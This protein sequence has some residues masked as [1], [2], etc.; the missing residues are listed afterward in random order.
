MGRIHMNAEQGISNS[1]VSSI[2]SGEK[3]LDKVIEKS[4]LVVDVTT[5]LHVPRI[6]SL[7][8]SFPRTVSAFITPSGKASVMLL[9]DENRAIRCSSLEAQ[10]Y[11]AILEEEWGEVHLSGHVGRQW[12][13]AGCREV[14]L[15]MSNEL[16]NLHAAILSRQIRVLSSHCDAK[17][18]IWEYQENSGGVVPHDIQVFPYHATTLNDWG[19]AWDDGFL[20]EVT[21]YRQGSLPN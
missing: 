1:F 2:V 12:V 13:G 5:T 10:Y 19:I 7:N 17:I 3:K 20:K 9:E 18:C 21:T 6:I 11:R 14:T 4:K 16:I 8:D 15:E